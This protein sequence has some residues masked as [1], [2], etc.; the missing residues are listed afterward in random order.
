MKT[1]MTATAIRNFEDVSWG[2]PKK[3]SCALLKVGQQY[4]VTDIEVHTWHTVVRLKE[5]PGVDFNSC[6]F[7]ESS[8]IVDAGRLEFVMNRFHKVT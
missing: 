5:F 7:K 4:E 6:W 1:S 2:R 8:Q 3:E